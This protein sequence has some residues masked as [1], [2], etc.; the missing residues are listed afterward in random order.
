MRHIWIIL[1]C[2]PLFCLA[3]GDVIGYHG[4]TVYHIR[5]HEVSPGT[6]RYT[7]ETDFNGALFQPIVTRYWTNY[8]WSVANGNILLNTSNYPT[9]TANDT[10]FIPAKSGGYRSFSMAG[11][12]SGTA[13]QYIV[14]YWQTGAFI[15]PTVS[16]IQANSINNI[17][18]VK[19]VGFTMNDHIDPAFTSYSSGQFSKYVWFDS[20]TFIGMN[21]FFP[22]A[23]LTL[24]TPDFTGDTT[25]CFYMWHW[26]RCIFDSLVGGNS[27]N[28]A[29]R[30]GGIAKNQ[31]WIHAEIDHCWFG[32][33]SSLLNPASY[34]AAFNTYGLYIHDDSLWN[35][36][37]N[38]A[39]PVGHTQS[40]LTQM[41]YFE[42][43]N[44]YFGPNNFGNCIRNLG[45]GD[46]PAMFVI[47][48][49]WSIGY[50][51]RSRIYNCIDAYSR[52][53]PFLETRT[54]P[55]D[56]ATLSPWVR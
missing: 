1:L 31:T 8:T 46:I 49:Q 30:I 41:C 54:D 32:D 6:I 15:T 4:E 52:K 44:C 55:G 29:I 25:N 34:I 39:S 27:G 38:V 7:E 33:Y 53:Y 21:G 47:F 26:S 5:S 17:F 9:V 14:V 22:S 10:I 11:I 36:G 16:T 40:I 37:K 28:S 42:I 48:A 24:S 12:N 13:G 18:G 23:P 2:M 20:C 35:L 43:Y 3:D 51:G 19:V 56:T 50:N 45:T